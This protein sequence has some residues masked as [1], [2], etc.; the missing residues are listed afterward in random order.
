MKRIP[1]AALLA[2]LSAFGV[3]ANAEVRQAAADGFFVA[4]SE[5]VAATP[6]KA[7]AAIV[8]VPAWWSGEHTWSGQA[9]NLSLKAEAG[10]CFCERWPG[11]SAEHGRVIMA[12]PDNLLRLDAALG[13]LQEF[14]L[15]GILSFWI[16]SNDDGSTRID[17]EYRVNG[18]G[19]S[20]LDA[21]A[22]QVDEMLGT[23]VARLK[24][25]LDT[26]KPDEPPQAAELTPTPD[27]LRAAMLEQWKREAEAA[28]AGDAKA[29]P[30]KP[31]KA[32]P[33][34]RDPAPKP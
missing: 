22:P 23:Q 16:R 14:A 24:R 30:D 32:K 27:A 18:A 6:A 13:P 21:L 19:A 1:L 4:Y 11:G 34:K 28:K 12:L 5:Q 33:S 20:G 25:Y 29:T 17:V 31:T 9:S 8:A 7:Y 2:S 10:G 26:G 3:T 15:K